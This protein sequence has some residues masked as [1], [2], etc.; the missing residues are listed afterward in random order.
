METTSNLLKQRREKAESL[1]EA[2][3]KL[4]NNTFKNPTPIA[5]VLPL[6]E[7]LLQPSATTIP[8]RCTV[9]PAG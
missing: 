2:G 8:A 9:L 7:S 5:D 1:A 3:V 4:F 6:G